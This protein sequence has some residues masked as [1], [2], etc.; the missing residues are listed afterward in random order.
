MYASKYSRSAIFSLAVGALIVGACSTEGLDETSA[1]PTPTAAA[2]GESKEAPGGE[3]DFIAGKQLY[4]EQLSQT[5]RLELWDQGQDGILISIRGHK[6]YDADKQQL[7]EKAVEAEGSDSASRIYRHLNPKH[8]VMPSALLDI[9]RL[10]EERLAGRATPNELAS[11]PMDTEIAQDADTT[12]RLVAT[13][14]PTALPLEGEAQ[15]TWM[16][17]WFRGQFCSYPNHD[18]S[19]CLLDR[20]PDPY[21]QQSSTG[22]NHIITANTDY[23]DIRFRGFSSDCQF[24][25]SWEQRWN[26]RVSAGH[27]AQNHWLGTSLTTDRRGRID[28]WDTN[29]KTGPLV[30]FA[31]TWRTTSGSGSTCKTTGQSCGSSFEC[32]IVSGGAQCLQG[33]CQKDP[34]P[35]SNCDWA[36]EFCCFGTAT[37]ESYCNRTADPNLR[38]AGGTC[39]R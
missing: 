9:D 29:N 22:R 28:A 39:V 18:K 30:Q 15:L 6:D 14:E 5:A 27:W 36:G 7:L 13:A 23:H 25:C 2:L 10:L 17:E 16:A 8:A 31:M 19:T 32:C 3:G 37:S 21:V 26:Y 38:C 34:T 35:N 24:W 11:R 12:G 20:A 4:V 1:E 33:V